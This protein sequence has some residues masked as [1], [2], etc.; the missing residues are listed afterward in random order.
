MSKNVPVFSA[1]T[2][3]FQKFRYNFRDLFSVR[4]FGKIFGKF[5]EIFGLSKLGPLYRT[6]FGLQNTGKPKIPGKSKA[7]FFFQM[8]G[9]SI[10][11]VSKNVLSL[12]R[13]HHNQVKLVH[14]PD[15]IS[16]LLVCTQYPRVQS[17][18]SRIP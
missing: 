16:V 3:N 5:G 15:M 4:I 18:Y 12:K 13:I 6:C 14:I 7:K 2:V 11:E 1:E 10:Y 9:L 8:H 17:L